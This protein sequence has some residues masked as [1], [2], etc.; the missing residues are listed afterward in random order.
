MHIVAGGLWFDTASPDSGPSSGNTYRTNDKIRIKATFGLNVR[1][2]GVR[3]DLYKIIEGQIANTDDPPDL[4]ENE[5]LPIELE[6]LSVRFMLGGHAQRADVV[7]RTDSDP[8]TTLTFEYVVQA[9]DRHRDQN[10][11]TPDLYIPANSIV[12][13]DYSQDKRPGFP[14]SLKPG[15]S[16]QNISGPCGGSDV[17]HHAVFHPDSPGSPTVIKPPKIMS[18]PPTGDTYYED[19]EIVVRIEFSQAVAVSGTPYIWI[20][21]GGQQRRAN[22]VVPTVKTALP[23]SRL[24]FAYEVHSSDIDTDGISVDDGQVHGGTIRALDNGPLASRYFVGLKAQADFIAHNGGDPTV[25]K[26]LIDG[27]NSRPLAPT[28]EDCRAAD[29]YDPDLEDLISFCRSSAHVVSYGTRI[30]SEPALGNMYTAGEYIIVRAEFASPVRVVND[31]LELA[32][33]FANCT[34]RDIAQLQRTDPDNGLYWTRL[35]QVQLIADY[36][37]KLINDGCI[38]SNGDRLAITRYAKYWKEEDR[39][40]QTRL[41]FR[42]EVVF[43]DTDSDGIVVPQGMFTYFNGTTSGN[44]ITQTN[45]DS[46]IEAVDGGSIYWHFSDVF[47]KPLKYQRANGKAVAG[48]PQGRFNR[49]HR[50]SRRRDR[51]TPTSSTISSRSRC[52]SP[53]RFPSTAR[54]C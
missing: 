19:E 12:A 22:Y 27:S 50:K 30:V 46:I 24:Q 48:R 32:I 16:L 21:V 6:P 7:P 51:T 42:Y 23:R 3:T 31:Q 13:E 29:P 45:V 5:V 37:Q 2:Y 1:D 47:D 43:D 41:L 36:R 39:S 54:Q 53:K 18:E 34:P 44:E 25:A 33:E 11:A 52:S 4:S 20:N 10:S 38:D 40:G 28:F 17:S 26:H 15:T 9:G 14:A 8:A 49:R 35:T